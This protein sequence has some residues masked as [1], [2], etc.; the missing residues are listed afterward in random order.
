MRKIKMIWLI[1]E[2][3]VFLMGAAIIVCG[4]ADIALPKSVWLLFAVLILVNFHKKN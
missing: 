4:F 2:I 1:L 3:S